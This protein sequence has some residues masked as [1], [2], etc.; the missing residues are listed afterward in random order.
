[1]TNTKFK[2]ERKYFSILTIFLLLYITI[3][4]QMCTQNSTQDIISLISQVENEVWNKGNI[5]LLDRIYDSN[6]ILHVGSSV[7]LEGTQGLKQMIQMFRN[8]IPDRNF[9]IDEI[10]TVG[11]KI[12]ERYTWQ[13]THKSI[14]KRVNVSGCVVYHLRDGKIVEAWNY[15]DMF[16]LYQQLGLNT[17]QSLFGQSDE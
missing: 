10:F 9:Q 15:E 2:K 17:S 3:S 14:G 13:G 11:N 7:I 12:T 6:C 8:V 1:M 5:D 16:G 4:N